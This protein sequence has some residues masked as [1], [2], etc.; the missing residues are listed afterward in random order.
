M[1]SHS[2]SEPHVFTSFPRG[3]ET[4]G[5]PNLEPSAE[6]QC[7]D[8]V[9]TTTGPNQREDQVTEEATETPPPGQQSTAVSVRDTLPPVVSQ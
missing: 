1:D 9:E 2:G 8:A 5:Q 4:K 3:E 7:A 6:G